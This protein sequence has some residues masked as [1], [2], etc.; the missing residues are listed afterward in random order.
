MK[1]AHIQTLTRL[2]RYSKAAAALLLVPAAYSQVAPSS[3]APAD[4]PPSEVPNTVVLSPFNVDTSRDVGYQAADTLQ[5][6][7][8][9]TPL[10]Q[11]PAAISVLTREFLDD[12]GATSFMSAAIWTTN[13]TLQNQNS[14][15]ADFQVN[16][17]GVGSGL[18]TINYFIF[19]NASD[20]YNTERLE[21]TRG[22]NAI[23]F[24]NGNLAGIPTTFT[25]QAHF[26][27]FT[28]F[29]G[30]IDSYGAY[31]TTLDE[32]REFLNGN[33]AIRVNLL[34][35]KDP[36]WR[37]NSR[38]DRQGIA[39]ASTWK[40]GDFADFRLEGE[41]G[42][43]QHSWGDSNFQDYSSAWDGKTTYAGP[44]AAA[45]NTTTSGL[46]PMGVDVNTDYLVYD[47]SNPTA[48]IQNQKGL[49]TTT[50][51][52]LS[53]L[54]NQAR[55]YIPNFPIL[56]SRTYNLQ[57]PNSTLHNEYH[58]YSAYL[59]KQVGDNLF[60]QLAANIDEYRRLLQ[61]G[62]WQA[63]SIDVNQTLNNGQL[64]P[65]YLQPFADVN[66]TQYP[67][68]DASNDLRFLGS[69]KLDTKWMKQ[70]FSL[71]ASENYQNYHETYFQQERL[72]NPG[73]PNLQDAANLVYQRRYF[74]QNAS[75]ADFTQP[76]S[77]NGYQVGMYQNEYFA[78][79]TRTYAEQAA[80]VGSYFNDTLTTIFGIRHDS[81]KRTTY[82]NGINPDNS[83]SI[84]GA[85]QSNTATRGSA[86]FVYYPI[87]WIGPFANYSE[88]YALPSLGNPLFDG[89]Q[90]PPDLRSHQGRRPSA[91]VFRRQAPGPNQLLRF[92]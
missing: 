91:Q 86:G 58:M 34:F 39:L 77:S 57:P 88:S 54:P 17:R 37:D 84:S 43:G 64:N 69:Y 26:L 30:R 85:Y 28:E 19:Q 92:T 1:R 44:G 15:F 20:S 33:A 32:N 71:L 60:M 81:N 62:T 53:I 7:R 36:R 21:F 48:G 56:N 73:D 18:Q 80:A 22:P 68:W 4:A 89:T 24:G 9:A 6:G 87:P 12:I 2:F 83:L 52:G 16:F 23:M 79:P 74:G 27:N 46:A 51:T 31:R 55:S 65:H 67:Q 35:Q 42:G 63:L 66:V 38:N 41:F 13:A 78:V 5:G 59:E 14:N 49:Y 50:G 47:P 3:A 72:N 70:Q 10:D 11:T 61:G 75:Y 40:I 76:V 90:G 8:I 25:K 45:P 82:S 29:Q